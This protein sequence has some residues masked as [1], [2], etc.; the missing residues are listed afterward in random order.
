MRNLEV[1]LLLF[2]IMNELYII[3]INFILLF[4]N[5]RNFIYELVVAWRSNFEALETIG[6]HREDL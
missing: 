4:I 6:A 2:I 1:L 5:N 3:V